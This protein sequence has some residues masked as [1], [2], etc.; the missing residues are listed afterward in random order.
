MI[1][2]MNTHI[3]QLTW[4]QSAG[5]RWCWWKRHPAGTTQPAGEGGVKKGDCV[6][7]GNALRDGKFN[8]SSNVPAQLL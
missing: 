8:V 5:L 2:A 4:M 6:D 1:L 3:K 7:A